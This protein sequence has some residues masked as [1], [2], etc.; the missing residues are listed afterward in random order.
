MRR[1]WPGATI[2]SLGKAPV[3]LRT[4]GR[5]KI[6]PADPG[7]VVFS[8]ESWP[9]LAT[10]IFF[11]G[12]RL[13]MMGMKLDRSFCS[14]V[15]RLASPNFTQ[16]CHMR[17]AVLMRLSILMMAPSLAGC[18]KK[19]Q[20]A[21]PAFVS[22]FSEATYRYFLAA[23]S[24]KTRGWG[25]TW[26][27]IDLDLESQRWN[28]DFP[29][30]GPGR[31]TNLKHVRWKAQVYPCEWGGVPGRRLPRGSLGQQAEPNLRGAMTVSSGRD[32]M[33]RI[34]AVLVSAGRSTCV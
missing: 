12:W 13:V 25:E 31:I 21:D 19:N 5:R 29:I 28:P 6:T 2:P 34:R 10:Y 27:G 3:L 20:G 9:W 11:D 14:V 17:L 16:I 30:C 1:P 33:C 7:H 26:L 23:A 8:R 32:A 22:R 4:D 15:R 18:Y 24:P